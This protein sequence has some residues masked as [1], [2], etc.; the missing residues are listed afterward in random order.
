M[1]GPGDIGRLRAAAVR[2]L[3]LAAL[4]GPA[5]ADTIYLRGGGKIE[6]LVETD[7]TQP[8]KV[9][10]LTRTSSRPFEF[11]KEQ[12]LRVE[13]QDDALREYV[14]RRDALE[15]ASAQEQYDLGV[16]CE[17]NGLLGPATAHFQR[18][19]ELDPGHADAHKKVGHVEL[20][21][22]WVTY[23]EL[24]QAQ[25][26]VKHKGKWISRQEK[27]ELDE[28]Q[29]FSAEQQSWARRLK[30]LRQKWLLG[31]PQQRA[32][33]EEQLA[34]IRDPS[35]VAPLVH[36]FG[37]DPAAVRIRLAKLVAA[38][39]GDE[40]AAALARL[41][42][43]E[44]ELEVRQEFLHQLVT[45]HDPETVT[46]F[47]RALGSK[48]VTVVG[49]AAW[50][51][52]MLDAVSAVPKLIPVLVK[53]EQQMVV[54][55]QANPSPGLSATFTSM[56][57]GP[58]LPGGAG[59]YAVGGGAGGTVGP[60]VGGGT[61]IPVLTG[62]VVGPGVVAFGA[63]SVPFGTGVGLNTGGGVNPN[64]PAVSVVTRV[65]RNEEVYQALVKLTGMDFGY[66]QD[67]WRR[68]QTTAFR[69]QPPAS[70]RVPQP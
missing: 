50:A 63:T 39:P 64:A 22:K 34:A 19:V 25:G 4:A 3:A 33:A 30:V 8:G 28:K 70:R 10:V 12:V 52:G 14:A 31:D 59:G 38:V 36:T 49:R 11:R 18:A 15:H 69:P 20:N 57:P 29:N 42:L 44:P 37:A 2:A 55:P 43:V 7:A 48:D 51:L 53:V 67:A 24:R 5:A 27:D 13:R 9:F 6:G 41:V 16:W 56:G 46:R 65:Y 23:D 61:S 40:A 35:A 60:Y 54:Q 66:D 45:R 62:P 21:G 32:Q 47:A 68:W 26:L 17:D 1:N 58:I